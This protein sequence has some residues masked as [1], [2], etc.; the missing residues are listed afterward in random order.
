[1][2]HR[3]PG[4]WNSMISEYSQNDLLHEAQTLFNAFQGKNVR[5]WTVLLT[6]YSK[7]RLVDEAR[8]LVK[9]M[10]VRNVVSWNAMISAYMQNSDLRSALRMSSNSMITRYCHCGTIKEAHELF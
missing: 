5:T 9:A 2:S 10:P 1:M 3:V 4:S 6:K 8:V 7:F